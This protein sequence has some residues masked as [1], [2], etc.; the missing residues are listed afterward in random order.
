MYLSFFGS[1]DQT[2]QSLSEAMS[3]GPSSPEEPEPQTSE[4][5][6][7]DLEV[8][9]DELSKDASARENH[10]TTGS[11]DSEGGPGRLP[12]S[13]VSSSHYSQSSEDLRVQRL[14]SSALHF[15]TLHTCF[16]SPIR[17]A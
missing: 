4:N 1:L 8:G 15:V 11:R 5:V 16:E 12:H 9:R 10:P 14:A 7:T 17:K 6:H 13:P 3:I 2:D